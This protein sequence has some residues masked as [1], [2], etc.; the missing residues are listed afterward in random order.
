[1]TQES[2]RALVSVYRNA[3]SE[4][5]SKALAACV[6]AYYNASP[7]SNRWADSLGFATAVH[8]STVSRADHAWMLGTGGIVSGTKAKRT[9][10]SYLDALA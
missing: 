10:N 1:M 8:G 6:V 5:K 7:S 9:V 3:P 4:H 2:I